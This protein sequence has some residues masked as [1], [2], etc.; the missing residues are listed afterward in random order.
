M[1]ILFQNLWTIIW[2]SFQA[3]KV[4]IWMK[5][6]MRDKYQIKVQTNLI[7][8]KAKAKEKEKEEKPV[9]A[10]MKSD[11]FMS[12]DFSDFLSEKYSINCH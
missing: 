11:L 7:L 12:I 4:K 8:K 2:I 3:W 6:M 9:K 10:L 1:K 5:K